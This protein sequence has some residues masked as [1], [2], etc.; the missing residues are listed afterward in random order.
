MIGD[1]IDRL[2]KEKDVKEKDKETKKEM[3]KEEEKSLGIISFE[4]KQMEELKKELLNRQDKIRENIEDTKNLR[5][6]IARTVSK[7]IENTRQIK[8]ET[9]TKELIFLDM[10]K[11]NEELKTSYHKYHILYENVLSER[12][13]NVKKIQSANQRRA[14]YKEKMKI[15]TTEMDILQSELEEIGNKYIEKKKDLAKVKQHQKSVKQ[16]INELQFKCKNHEEEIKKLT[17][18]NEKLHSILNSIENDMVSLR[19][20][21]EVTINNLA[22][23]R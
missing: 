5:E 9:Q 13:N 18:E 23:M 3:K 12:N 7:L 19:V 17:N 16:E 4:K 8:E 11:K 20:E 22:S 2:E 1:E 10:T 6:T 14:E 15:I 21:Y